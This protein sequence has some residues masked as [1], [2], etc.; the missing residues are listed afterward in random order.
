MVFIP[1][2]LYAGPWGEQGRIEVSEQNPHYLAYE[3]GT[4]LFWLGDTAWSLF[5][6][7]CR[8]EAAIGYWSLMVLISDSPQTL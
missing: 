1:T 4:P 5:S 2:Y 3:D 6:R 8:D 7:L